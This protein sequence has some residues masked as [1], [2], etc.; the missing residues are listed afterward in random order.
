MLDTGRWRHRK[1]VAEV[2]IL[3]IMLEE[4]AMQGNQKAAEYLH[5]AEW[6]LQKFTEAVY[7][8]RLSYIH[9][10][11]AKKQL[12]DYI[13]FATPKPTKR[14]ISARKGGAS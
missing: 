12:S 11:G 6:E 4:M 3:Y 8:N 9:Y 7:N 10:L 1:L 5:G 13:L 14:G 2:E